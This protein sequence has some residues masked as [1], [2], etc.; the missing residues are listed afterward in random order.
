MPR[1][2][3]SA[4]G[5]G[6]PGTASANRT[7]MANQTPPG[8]PYGEAGRLQAGMAQ[9]P[10]PR[11]GPLPLPPPAP[12][13]AGPGGPSGAPPALAQ[14]PA[15]GVPAGSNP[16]ASGLAQILAAAGSMAPP[17][18]PGLSAPT[19]RPDEPVTTG[20]PIG[21]GAGPEALAAN[22]QMNRPSPLAMI[23]NTTAQTTGSSVL[24]NLAAAAAA[25][26][27]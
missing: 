22:G 14:G 17:S 18:G 23:L 12:T 10:V 26:G 9:V 13:A 20:L 5:A 27:L 15:P 2:G 8:L 6:L 1:K 21:P 11:Q 3:R 7:D 24:A 16:P 4:K 25:Q 19:A